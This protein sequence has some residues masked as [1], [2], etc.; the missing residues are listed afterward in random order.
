M[1]GTVATVNVKDILQIIV[2]G[3]QIVV[4]PLTGISIIS[5]MRKNRAALD[6]QKKD[7]SQKTTIEKAEYTNRF[8]ENF[9]ALLSEITAIGYVKTFYMQEVKLDVVDKE[10]SKI[11]RLEF[12][13]EFYE[14][15]LK[16]AGKTR[17]KIQ[18]ILDIDGKLENGY[19]DIT[20]NIYNIT[21]MSGRTEFHRC[22]EKY[23][24]AR[25]YE[26]SRSSIKIDLTKDDDKQQ[27][28][29]NVIS[30]ISESISEFESNVNE[31]D[32]KIGSALDDILIQ[33]IETIEANLLN[34]MECLCMNASFGL[35]EYEQ[36]YHLVVA[37]FESFVKMMYIDIIESVLR[38]KKENYNYYTNLITVYGKLMDIKKNHMNSITEVEEKFNKEREELKS[39]RTK[40]EQERKREINDK[41]ENTIKSTQKEYE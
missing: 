34:E 27:I 39:K 7:R 3:I 13:E 4:I 14:I 31:N 2:F 10:I 40:L 30:K 33:N 19:V 5:T 22:V 1:E 9:K 24:N 18:S 29:D 32:K 16:N 8:V 25:K 41:K 20:A 38:G 6:M 17:S 15:I 36:I 11:E 26:E 12:T 35:I 23:R 21:G 28:L 37:P